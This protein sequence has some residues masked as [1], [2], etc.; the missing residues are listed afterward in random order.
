MPIISIMA[1]QSPCSASLLIAC[2][3]GR[4]IVAAVSGFIAEHGGNLLASDQHTDLQHGEFFMRANFELH[5]C[6]LDRSS[7]DAAWKPLANRFNMNWHVHWSEDVKRMTIIVGKQAHCLQDLIWRWQAGELNVHIPM[8]IS[9]HKTLESIAT[10]AGIEFHHCPIEDG[11]KEVQQNKIKSII[12]KANIDLVVLARYMQILSPEFLDGYEGRIIN[13]HHSFLPAF[14]GGYPYRQAYVRGVKIIGATS[15]YVTDD[16]DDGPIITQE[17]VDVSH[18]DSVDDLRRK[19]RDLERTVLA[20]AVRYH[21]EDKILVSQN[22]T[23]VF[24]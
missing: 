18:R 13:I 5:D 21:V 4:G 6:D 1:S 8:I 19:G 14:A 16:L 2:P 11:E 10:D 12:N 7:F 3:D 23:V 15:H 20:R 24:E 9:N 17:V 22:K